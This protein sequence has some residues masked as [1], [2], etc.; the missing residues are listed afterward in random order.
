MSIAAKK[1]PIMPKGEENAAG[2]SAA[3]IYKFEKHPEY[4]CY[5]YL[6]LNNH[7][8]LFVFNRDYLIPIQQIQQITFRIAFAAGRGVSFVVNPE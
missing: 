8:S 2:V 6:K 3:V 5:L 4:D 7:F 1:A